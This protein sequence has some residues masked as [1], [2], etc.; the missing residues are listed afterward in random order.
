MSDIVAPLLQWLN[1]NPQWAGLVTF[2]ISASESVAIIGTI[3]PG[4][5]T[6]TAIGALAGAGIIP[7]WETLFWAML[8]AVIG[9]GIS[10]WMGHYFNDRLRRI[11]P[12]S[13]N[14]NLLEQG[15]GFVLKYGA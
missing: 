14:P 11:W 12:F 13:T 4:S 6:M 15:E 9:D 1:A 3:V 10:C 5:I 7:L 2:I 8:G